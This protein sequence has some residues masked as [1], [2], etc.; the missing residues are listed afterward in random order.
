MHVALSRVLLTALLLMLMPAG[1]PAA[2]LPRS[3]DP[4]FDR[5]IALVN[6][7]FHDETGLDRFNE[8]AKKEIEDVGQTLPQRGSTAR[9]DAAIDATIASLRASHNGR[10]KPDT[11]AYF[12]LS[13]IFRFAIRNDL[14]RL[15]PPEGDV[16]YPGIGLVTQ[17]IGDRRFVSD[18]YDGSPAATAG[19]LMGDEILSVDD[20]PYREIASFEGKV[21][22]SVGIRLRRKADGAPVTVKVAVERLPPLP[23]LAKAIANSI[24]V[25]E[26]GGRKIG[27][28]RFWTL[29]TRDGLDV[30]A[31]ELYDGRLSGV[32]G[33]IVDLRGRWGGGAA[34]A[35]ELF[36][37]D[38]PS[39][40][41]IPRHGQP[42]LAN[43]RWRGP[44]VA[45][46]DEGTRSGLELFA[47]ALRING[48]PLVGQ[49]T[50]GALLAGRAYI[51]PDDSLLEIAVSDAVIDDN[52]RLEGNGIAP[53]IPVDLPLAYAAGRDPQREAAVSEMLRLLADGS[54]NRV[55]MP[56]EPLLT[57]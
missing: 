26:H 42:T 5:V 31:R 24:A 52:V 15:F 18:V 37:G 30:V 43:V 11:I 51:L 33:V 49:R 2:E 27:Y 32:D 20:L 13:D 45:L 55:V 46:I 25:I 40:R 22:Q 23:T 4:V 17:T 39:F 41:L 34:D 19:V 9:V 54:S 8:T 48:I 28:V 47:Y 57:P 10:F 35:A 56:A 16:T 44:V 53:D 21:G 6:S 3:G 29:S 1:A 14:R 12:E 38:T 7:E 36:V 50:A